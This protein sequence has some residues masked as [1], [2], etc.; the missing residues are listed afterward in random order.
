M[1]KIF[2][3]K[4]MNE[5]CNNEAMDIWLNS[6]E[7]TLDCPKCLT[8]KM[9]AKMCGTYPIIYRGVDYQNPANSYRASKPEI[10]YK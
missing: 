1:S 6:H 10:V 9:K 5:D 3:M 4:C 7:E 2:D 8:H